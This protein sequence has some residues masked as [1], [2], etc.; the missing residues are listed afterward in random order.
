M[1]TGVD[2]AVGVCEFGGGWMPPG[3][4]FMLFLSETIGCFEGCEP[5]LIAKAQRFVTGV[6]ADQF[7]MANGSETER[8]F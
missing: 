4:G 8:E 3:S 1:E 5:L 2:D 6:F 7:K